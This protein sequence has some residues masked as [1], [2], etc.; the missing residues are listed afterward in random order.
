MKGT[1]KGAW[2]YRQF[3]ISSI[4]TELLAR[5][6]R[7]KLGLVWM[8][9]HPLAQV[10]IYAFVLSV[11]LSTKLPGIESAYGYASYLMAGM[12]AWS[13]FS[14]IVMRCLNIFLENG[15]LL[16]K[17]VFPKICLPLI[18]S[19][20]ALVSNIALLLATLVVFS[21]FDHIP[22]RSLLL[23]PTLIALNIALAIGLGLIL[24]ILNVFIRD[25]G[26]IVPVIFQFW[27]WLTPIVYMSGIIPER[28]RG[29]L[30]LNPMYP[31]VTAY[32]NVL[33]FGKTP[34]WGGLGWVSI[35]AAILLIM[36]LYMFRKASPEI[37]D[38]L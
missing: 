4:K 9:L 5:Y 24:G 26:Q 2:H 30:S 15:N 23:L 14:E 8:L 38:V 34:Y 12:L 22:G 7:S 1:F 17:L 18:V 27:F 11:V 6:A 35:F 19:G 37:V 20:S 28:F 25:V 10:A 13:L 33:V 21:L 31:I 16:K 36:A 3:I 29:W 32:Q